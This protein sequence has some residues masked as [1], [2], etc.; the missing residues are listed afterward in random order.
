MTQINN[1]LIK[2]I[3]N[4]FTLEQMKMII[5]IMAILFFIADVCMIYCCLQILFDKD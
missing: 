4:T 1:Y 5:I 3:Q 2:L